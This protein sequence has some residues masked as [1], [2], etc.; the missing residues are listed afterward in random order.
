MAK[1]TMN[2]WSKL[3]EPGVVQ[4]ML[5]NADSHY[6]TL[7]YELIPLM[8]RKAMLRAHLPSSL[9]EDI[10]Q[11]VME[12]LVR[13]LSHLRK[14]GSF[15]AW[16]AQVVASKVVD[17]Q[18][19]SIRRDRPCTSLEQLKDDEGEIEYFAVPAIRATESECLIREQLR[20]AIAKLRMFLALHRKAGRNAEILHAVLLD[21]RKC[22]D[23][24]R[25]LE[26]DCQVVRYVVSMARRYLLVQE[27]A[28]DLD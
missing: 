11:Q 28:E 14:E 18:R 16:L 15:I 23:V 10:I 22:A 3:K 4:E 19:Y 25:E 26:I 6:W 7:C 8:V 21:D 2:A 20:E 24:A 17:A 13:D 9:E 12:A 1:T 27:F 5:S